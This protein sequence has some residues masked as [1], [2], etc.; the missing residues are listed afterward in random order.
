MGLSTGLVKFITDPDLEDEHADIP[1][2]TLAASLL[3]AAL[4]LLL[5]W[6]SAPHMARLLLGGVEGASLFRLLGLYV[7]FKAVAGVPF[8]LIRTHERAGLY[9]AGTLVEAVLLIG[10]VYYFLAVHQMGLEG[11]LQ[12]YVWSAGASA[13]ILI[14]G[15]LRQVRWRLRLSLARRLVRFSAPLVLAGIAL[16]VLHVGDRYLLEWLS[17]TEELAVYGWAARLSGVL[18]MLVVQSFHLAFL[19]VGL[20]A[21]GGTEGAALHRRVFR[22]YTIWTGYVVIGLSLLAYD[23]TALLAA[24]DLYLD[25]ALQVFPLSLG[26]L[27]YGF[28]II[29][30]NAMYAADRPGFVTLTVSGSA[31]VNL[32]LNVLLIPSMGGIGAALATLAAYTFLAIAMTWAAERFLQAGFPWRVLFTVVA[33][34]VVLWGLAQPALQWRVPLRLLWI[35]ALLAAYP[36]LI[37]ATGLYSRSEIALAWRRIRHRAGV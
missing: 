27:A 23:V 32:V 33:T 35:T 8:M 14:A 21:L 34:I 18:N 1:F 15:M 37:V 29:S 24:E 7:V 13:A 25:A 6:A 30:V 11:V 22:H 3:F 12:A 10:G 4:G 20:K 9:V 16:P 31:V 28:F 36:L 17:T 26:Y 5:L 19:V 2:T